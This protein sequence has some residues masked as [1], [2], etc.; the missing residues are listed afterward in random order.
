MECSE[1]KDIAQV[2]DATTIAMSILAND[3]FAM[4]ETSAI[5]TQMPMSESVTVQDSLVIESAKSLSEQFIVSATPTVLSASSS[6]LGEDVGVTDIC[7]TFL[8]AG[9]GGGKFNE[10]QLNG[11]TFN[12]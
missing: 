6:L 11:F 1:F 2:S 12:E 3:L 5:Q 7:L 4:T 8:Y 9:L 10:A